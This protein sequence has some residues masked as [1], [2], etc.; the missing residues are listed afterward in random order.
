MLG[1]RWLGQGDDG[2]V[3]TWLKGGRSAFAH[4]IHA[5]QA[6]AATDAR[7]EVCFLCY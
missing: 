6:L 3:R 4:T 1:R 7:H 5:K 2:L